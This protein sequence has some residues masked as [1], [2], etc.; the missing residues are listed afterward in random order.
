[1]RSSLCW[2]VGPAEKRTL[3]RRLNLTLDPIGL[4]P[5]LA[6][7]DAFL[8]DDSPGAYEKVVDRLLGSGQLGTRYGRHRLSSSVRSRP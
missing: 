6:E 5:K 7:Q 8:R 2:M 3:L 1:M 4:T